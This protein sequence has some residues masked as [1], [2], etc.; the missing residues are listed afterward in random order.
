MIWL[1]TL[2]PREWLQRAL[3][4]QWAATLSRGDRVRLAYWGATGNNH[5]EFQW[6]DVLPNNNKEKS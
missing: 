2:L 1:L 3:Y 5:H 6:A 4:R